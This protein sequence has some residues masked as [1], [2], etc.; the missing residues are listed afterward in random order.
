MD[1]YDFFNAVLDTQIAHIGKPAT[2]VD[3]KKV[4]VYIS[5]VTK[6][7]KPLLY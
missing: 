4:K 5:T 3:Q 1:A 6:I 2:A 7:L